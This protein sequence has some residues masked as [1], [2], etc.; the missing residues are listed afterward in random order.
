MGLGAYLAAVTE[1]DHYFS[2]EK[3]ER[4]KL[5]MRPTVEKDVCC[6]LL[7]TYDISKEASDLV[8]QNLCRDYENWVH[9]MMDFVL[10]LE[11]PNVSRAW[12]SAGTMGAAYFIGG[13]IPMIPYF[14]VHNTA[15]ALFISSAITV[16]ILLGFGYIKNWITVGTKRSAVYG[17]LQTLFVGVSAAGASY[18]IVKAIE[19]SGFGEGDTGS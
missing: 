10:K 3:R 12:I 16:V 18:G 11:K 1:R 13:L 7:E 5:T 19:C 17:A 4:A 8:M 6:D 9:F 15:H 2:E 14:A